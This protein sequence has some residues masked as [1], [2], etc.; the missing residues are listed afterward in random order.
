ME[1]L[2]RS[3]ASPMCP[4]AGAVPA[5]LLAAC[6]LAAC[7]APQPE[8]RPD[9]S[10]PVAVVGG[11]AIPAEWIS[12]VARRDG[13]SV[14]GALERTIDVA[15]LA[16]AARRAGIGGDPRTLAET[17]S[18][19]ARMA[20]RREVELPP[21]DAFTERDRREVEAL[22]RSSVAYF[23]H[24]ELRTVRHL[25]VVLKSPQGG[26]QVEPERPAAE[27]NAGLAAIEAILPLVR[28]AASGA[29]VQAMQ[30]IL[31][32]RLE[33]AWES[34]GLDPKR[35]PR[36]VAEA[37]GPMAREDAYDPAFLEASFALGASGD[38]AGPVRTA[39]GWH[40]IRLEGIDPP[41][42]APH[43]E[44]IA[45][46]IERGGLLIERGRFEALM[47]GAR[48]KYRVVSHPELLRLAAPPELGP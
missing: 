32:V 26:R 42:D 48:E 41:R 18:L 10:R 14:E 9:A 38:V 27:W 28:G 16:E 24:P 45:E 13:L 7:R 4:A 8:A 46:T 21:P 44:A 11:R 17:R 30:P 1:R 5:A 2:V 23:T 20:L 34:A 15:A 37:I 40:A 6:A 22:Y 3:C 43:D 29:A 35:I 12:M 36:V 19:M 33:A 47:R 39:F 31:Q 25:A